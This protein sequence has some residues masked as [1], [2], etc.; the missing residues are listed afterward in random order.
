MDHKKHSRRNQGEQTGDNRLGNRAR[1]GTPGPFDVAEGAESRQIGFDRIF[2]VLVKG[3]NIGAAALLGQT[4]GGIYDFVVF[5]PTE[6]IKVDRKSVEIGVDAFAV[7]LQGV[8]A[9]FSENDSAVY[10]VEIRIAGPG[11]K[12]IVD[13]GGELGVVFSKIVVGS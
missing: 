1:R 4:T 5:P 11:L 13:G 6:T 9:A 10:V 8:K 12:D 7:F 2:R 3:C